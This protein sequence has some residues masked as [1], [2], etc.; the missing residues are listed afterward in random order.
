MIYVLKLKFPLEQELIAEGKILH[1][2][3]LPDLSQ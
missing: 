1:F 3:V 2:I